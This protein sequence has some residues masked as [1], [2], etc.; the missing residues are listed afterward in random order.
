MHPD[1]STTYS[2]LA[3]VLTSELRVIS[4]PGP[5][6]N[7]YPFAN[8]WDPNSHFFNRDDGLLLKLE[9]KK[10]SDPGSGTGGGVTYEFT[11]GEVRSKDFYGYGTYSVCMKPAKVS[12]TSASFFVFNGQY[13]TPSDAGRWCND[14]NGAR[15]LHVILKPPQAVVLAK[16]FNLVIFSL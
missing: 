8:G 12:G 3:P 7:G 11:S 4:H 2:E 5:W 15:L 10:F 13:D 1:I 14:H 6:S 16:H 9:R